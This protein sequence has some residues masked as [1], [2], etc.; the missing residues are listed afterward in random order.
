MVKNPNLNI[1]NIHFKYVFDCNDQLADG[2]IFYELNSQ[3]GE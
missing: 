1:T 2:F 3:N